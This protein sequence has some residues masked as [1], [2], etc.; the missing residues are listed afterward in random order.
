MRK[1][2]SA[3]PILTALLMLL[4]AMGLIAGCGSDKE[5]TKTSKPAKDSKAKAKSKFYKVGYEKYGLTK[6]RGKINLYKPNELEAISKA[7]GPDLATMVFVGDILL[8]DRTKDL[9]SKHGWGYPFGG[10]LPLLKNADVAIGNLE[11]PLTKDAAL[12]STQGYFYKV[13]P[14]SVNGLI[15][16]GFD[17]VTLANNHLLDCSEP[18]LKETI[19]VLDKAKIGWFG[20]G[21]SDKEARKP[22]ISKIKGV[23]VAMIGGISPEI[24]FPTT[25]TM[26]NPERI[27]LRVALCEKDLSMINGANTMGTFIYS[28]ETLKED[29]ANARKTADVVIVNLHMGVRYWR[30]PYKAQVALAKAAVEAGADLIIGHHAHFWQPIEMMGNVPVIYGI[31]NFAFGSANRNAD[32]GLLV[33]AFLNV[34]EKRISKVELFPTYIKN[35]DDRINYQSKILKGDAAQAVLEDIQIWSSKTCNTDLNIVGDRIVIE[36]PSKGQQ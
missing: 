30:P 36:I 28:P 24:Y 26:S 13:P 12:R 6:T 33:R 31:G 18:G 34:K 15:E 21:S 32:E 4:F 3:H 27:K 9:I 29:I 23:K 5:K 10:V 1:T 8:W 2:F 35:R 25:K 16:G 22:Y 19:A 11:G 7:S 20:A 17:I 14:D